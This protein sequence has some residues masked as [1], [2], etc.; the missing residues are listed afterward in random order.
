MLDRLQ[1]LTDQTVSILTFYELNQSYP[2][3]GYLGGGVVSVK[4][5]HVISTR[6]KAPW[7]GTYNYF[8]KHY[9]SAQGLTQGLSFSR[10]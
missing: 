9:P 7:V 10:A 5:S 4:N 1:L 6:Q 3:T 2:P 8:A